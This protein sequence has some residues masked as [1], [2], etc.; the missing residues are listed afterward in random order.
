MEILF[1]TKRAA[2]YCSELSN[3]CAF[4]YS[5]GPE[6]GNEE[7]SGT[8]PAAQGPLSFADEIAYKVKR[9][10]H[11]RCTPQL[12][13]N[14]SQDSVDGAVGARSYNTFLPLPQ[15]EFASNSFCFALSQTINQSLQPMHLA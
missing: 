14:L 1:S 15:E 6:D 12:R 2:K 13:P 9:M 11:E 10:P 7:P 5:I 8:E 3:Q 4:S